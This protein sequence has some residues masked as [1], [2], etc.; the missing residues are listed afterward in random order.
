[1]LS[2]DVDDSKVVEN[3]HVFPKTASIIEDITI[4]F[5]T[6]IFDEA[7]MSSGSTGDVNEI[8][9]SNIRSALQVNQVPLC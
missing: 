8:V 3:V 9:E 4:D 1:V 5:G 2:V 7:H 6:L